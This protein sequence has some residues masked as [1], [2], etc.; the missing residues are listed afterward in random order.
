MTL[1]RKC[2]RALTFEN[3]CRD[4][5]GISEVEVR[6]GALHALPRLQLILDTSEADGKSELADDIF[7]HLGCE[8]NTECLRA[9]LACLL[10]LPPPSLRCLEDGGS[11]RLSCAQLQRL[12][13][14]SEPW[15][16]G[17]AQV[18]LARVCK[19]AIAVEPRE[20]LGGEEEE[21]E[22]EEEEHEECEFALAVEPYE[23]LQSGGAAGENAGKSGCLGAFLTGNFERWIE[24][25]EEN[26]SPSHALLSRR[27]AAHAIAA[28]GLLSSARPKQCRGRT[29]SNASR[30]PQ[31]RNGG[32]G[33]ASGLLSSSFSAS[34]CAA[35][36]TDGGAG[37]GG[38][39]WRVCG[40]GGAG[41]RLTEVVV[42]GW[43][44]AMR[45]LQDEDSSVSSPVA[46]ALHDENCSSGGEGS[47][48]LEEVLGGRGAGVGG[49]GREEEVGLL[50]GGGLCSPLALLEAASS[51]VRLMHRQRVGQEYLWRYLR[52][53]VRA[54]SEE[55]RRPSQYLHPLPKLLSAGHGAEGEGGG[56]GR[57]EGEGGGEEKGGV[58]L[59]ETRYAAV[60]NGSSNNGHC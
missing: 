50:V 55:A 54:S 23:E 19:H 1:H 34:P 9:S 38:C 27:A 7:R 2:T 44:C 20:K 16:R 53:L 37:V 49:G 60:P 36:Q 43:V 32:N 3:L 15:E 47:W 26:C 11:T 18:V 45:L 52:E 25:V 21:E 35:T 13:S 5:L 48:I 30:N 6:L 17:M 31:G 59:Q 57:G 46:L 22:E 29:G 58:L 33:V 40:C 12:C 14:S 4:L 10:D 39:G 28:S 56:G 41:R 24:T 42:R 51:V 8:Q